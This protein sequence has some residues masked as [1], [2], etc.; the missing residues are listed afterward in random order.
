MNFVQMSIDRYQ[1]ELPKRIKERGKHAH[2]VH[3]ELVQA[4]KWKQSVSAA[5]I[6]IRIK[7]SIFVNKSNDSNFSVLFSILLQF[8]T[9]IAWQILSS[10]VIFDQSKYAARRNAGNQKSIS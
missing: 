8:A 9:K 2:L 7:A 6:F 5:A 4:M 1:N 3:E 10:I